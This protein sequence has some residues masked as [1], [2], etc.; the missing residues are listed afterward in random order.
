[1]RGLKEKMKMQD[2]SVTDGVQ[3]RKASLFD[4][5]A[6]VATNGGQMCFYILIMYASYIGTEGY[7]IAVATVG[8]ILSITKV[9]DGVTDALAAALI[10]KMP[11][12]HGKIR[13]C[14]AAG[15]IIACTTGV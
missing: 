11:G 8:V 10:E 4:M 7:G 9:F 1:M 14:V 5:I 2:A 15:F 12:T 3:Y 13:I 6:S